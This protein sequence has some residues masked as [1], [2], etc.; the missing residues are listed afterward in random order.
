MP[1]STTIQSSRVLVAHSD[2]SLTLF[3]LVVYILWTCGVGETGVFEL[4]LQTSTAQ[5]E[6]KIVT[7]R[8]EDRYTMNDPPR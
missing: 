3:C 6:C 8:V 1:P 4:H 7:L 2:T 5:I